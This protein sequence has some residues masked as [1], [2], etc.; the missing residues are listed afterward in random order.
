[1]GQILIG[2]NMEY[3]RHH[4][5]PFAAGVEKAAQL[6][7]RYIEPMVHWGR[8]L[9]SEALYF[10]TQSMFDDPKDVRA[11][12]DRHGIQCSAISAHCPL[13]RPDVSELYL[14]SADRN[15][16]ERATTVVNTDE[17]VKAEG[18][19][20]ETDHVL[21]K[22]TLGK[23]LRCAEH[24]GI[25]IGLEQHQQYTRTPAG[26]DRIFNLVK[27]PMMGINFDTGNAYLAGQDPYKW[28]ADVGDRLVHVH[29]KDISIQQ[30]DA[31]R[32]KVAGT[33]VGC[34]CGEGVIDWK[35][36]IRIIRKVDRP[37]CLSVECGTID[38]AAASID[39]LK[40]LV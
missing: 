7:Y 25:H 33:P 38:Q 35:E 20:I 29:A 34:A 21:M 13:G 9:M 14:T 28:L 30:S 22:Y 26:M 11:L 6:G 3:V 37:I 5:M 12:C 17:G 8:E 23:V 27:S 39:H 15:P 40:S 32:G 36:T 16:A 18:T 4:D 31:E 10:H 24:R 19:D 2:L 1:M